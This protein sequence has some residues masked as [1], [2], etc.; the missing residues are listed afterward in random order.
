MRDQTP[1]VPIRESDCASLARIGCAEADDVVVVD[2]P[3]VFSGREQAEAPSASRARDDVSSRVDEIDA[4]RRADA[5]LNER[6]I[7]TGEAELRLHDTNATTVIANGSRE[8]DDRLTGGAVL[9]RSGL[10]DATLPGQLPPVLVALHEVVRGRRHDG[11]EAVLVG[12][13]DFGDVELRQKVEQKV[14]RGG[15]YL[16]GASCLEPL[17]ERRDGQERQ[18]AAS[19]NVGALLRRLDHRRFP[20]NQIDLS[21]AVRRARDRRA[22]RIGAR[23]RKE[24]RSA[25]ASSTA[26]DATLPIAVTTM[27]SAHRDAA[28]RDDIA[29]SQ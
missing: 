15:V 22:A 7:D 10:A 19:R 16:L 8:L 6:R 2:A 13:H 20:G 26:R 18:S 14:Q 25:A 1:V 24:L 11:V 4:K 9:D 5:G 23:R 27:S 21:R 29:A 17:L 28:G 12:E 3:Q